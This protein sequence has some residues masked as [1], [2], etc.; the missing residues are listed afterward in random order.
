MQRP[1]SIFLNNIICHSF[2]SSRNNVFFYWSL[3]FT[4]L[5]WSDAANSIKS[6]TLTTIPVHWTLVYNSIMSITACKTYPTTREEHQFG[7]FGLIVTNELWIS[8]GS[9][10]AYHDAISWCQR[11]TLFNF[12][13]IFCNFKPLNFYFFFNI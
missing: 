2:H 9:W 13:F 11:Q 12:V 3:P 4:L 8:A 7:L 5:A 1:I 6:Y 10:I